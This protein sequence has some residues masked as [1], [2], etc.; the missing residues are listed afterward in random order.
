MQTA[1]KQLLARPRG[2]LAVVSENNKF[3]IFQ[4]SSLRLSY[5]SVSFPNQGHAVNN[6]LVLRV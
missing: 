5:V 2:N 6:C 3:F 4:K 1:A